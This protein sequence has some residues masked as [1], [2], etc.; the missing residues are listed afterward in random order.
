MEEKINRRPHRLEITN[1]ERGSVTGLQDVVSFDENQIILD[2]DQGL[3]TIKGKG[4][5]VSRL[6]LEKGEVDIDGRFD[7]FAYSSNEGYRKSGESLLGRLF[8]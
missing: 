8:K 4:L 1:R 6:T 5:H 3:L 7:S 2:T